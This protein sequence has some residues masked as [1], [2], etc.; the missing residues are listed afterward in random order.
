MSV[1]HETNLQ[2]RSEATT[3]ANWDQV[4][5]YELVKKMLNHVMR[6]LNS[7][8]VV[9]CGI[10]L[11]SVGDTRAVGTMDR[12]FLRSWWM[13][14]LNLGS[15]H[16]IEPRVLPEWLNWFLATFYSLLHGAASARCQN[17][18]RPHFSSETKK[19]C[20]HRCAE[21]WNLHRWAEEFTLFSVLCGI[22]K[23][24]LC[25]PTGRDQ[26]WYWKVFFWGSNTT[27][28]NRYFNAFKYISGS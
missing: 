16:T 28:F 23:C 19:L 9:Y 4:W 13:F 22:F 14:I 5:L 21:M 11:W 27:V 3:V 6:S 1:P 20:V 25:H 12:S 26:R 18:L 15:A 24:E 2:R 8:F 7:H 17:D 10:F